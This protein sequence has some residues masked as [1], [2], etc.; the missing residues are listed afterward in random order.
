MN[1][2]ILGNA[3]PEATRDLARDKAKQYAQA[4][5]NAYEI[6]RRTCTR[7]WC[8]LPNRGILALDVLYFILPAGSKAPAES[9]RLEAVEP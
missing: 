2:T 4:T 7:D 3:H 1:Q 9:I 8:D 6:W 5:G